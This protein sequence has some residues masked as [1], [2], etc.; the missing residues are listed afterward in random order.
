MQ[1]IAIKKA[2]KNNKT[3][4]VVNSISLKNKDNAI[5]QKIPHPM[6]T[7]V[8]IF[9]KLEDAQ[10]AIVLAGFSYIM[11][12]GKKGFAKLPEDK[13]EDSQHSY[14]KIVLETIKNKLNSNNSTVCASAVLALSEFPSQEN[15]DILFEKIGE[16]NDS[17]RKNAIAGICKYSNMLQNQIIKAL[18]HENWVTRNSAITCIL[19][20]VESGDS[21]AEKYL[22]PLVKAC[23][24]PNP[25]V[26]ANAVSALAKVYKLYLK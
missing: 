16:D 25:I 26:E 12:D 22:L 4:Y 14:E 21:D 19:N 8:L 10:N 6:G 2:Q 11:P 9:E 18:K 24:D 23:S 15:F 7:D 3:V 13:K 5:V 20:S 1:Y 17:I